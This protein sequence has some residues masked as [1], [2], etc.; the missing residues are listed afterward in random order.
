MNYLVDTNV[1]S[2]V[3]PARTGRPQA[4][5]DW[6]DRAS[7]RLILSVVTLTEILN[8]IFN[9]ERE[10]ATRRATLLREW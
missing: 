7:E 8:G 1:I 4:L 6:L 5:I 9:T 2:A 3:A 10:G